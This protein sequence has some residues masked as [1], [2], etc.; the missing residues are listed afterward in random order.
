MSADLMTAIRERRGSALTVR[1]RER[2]VE[3][4]SRG[5]TT[6]FGMYGVYMVTLQLMYRGEHE[7]RL[8]LVSRSFIVDAHFGLNS[9]LSVQFC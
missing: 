9:F 3:R 8:T 7:T 5:Y 2:G 4:G 1:A 6:S